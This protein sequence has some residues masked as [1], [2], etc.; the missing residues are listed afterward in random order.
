MIR[1]IAALAAILF[2]AGAAYADPVEGSWKTE[3]DDGNYAIISMK[4]CG[5]KLCGTIARTFNSAGEFKSEVIGR[6]LV[7]DMVP[8]GGGA[9]GDG[10]I[11][12]PSNDKVYR[13]KMKLSGNSLKVSGCFGPVCLGQHWTR[14]Q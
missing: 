14:V 2:C 6:Q 7:W 8:E 10:K 5:A 1:P 3:V 13:S 9:Y 4:T 12:R 11:W